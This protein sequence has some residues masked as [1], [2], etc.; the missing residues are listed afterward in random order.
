MLKQT[1]VYWAPSGIDD[2]GRPT[3]DDPVELD[4]RWEDVAE[5][6]IDAAGERQLS[7]AKVFVESDVEVHGVLM[8]GELT[9]LESG[10]DPLEHEDAWEILKFAKIP[11]LRATEYL[12][13][14]FLG[15]AYR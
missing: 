9:D 6:F 14:A 7:A 1:A 3:W 10:A 13:T 15:Q 5:E 11:N 4:C 12:R 8:L 2:F